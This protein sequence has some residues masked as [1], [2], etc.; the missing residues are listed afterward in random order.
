MLNDVDVNFSFKANEKKT[1]KIVETNEEKNE[2]KIQ[3]KDVKP[4]KDIPKVDNSKNNKDI[5]IKP[6][7]KAPEKNAIDSKMKNSILNSYVSVKKYIW[8]YVIIE[9]L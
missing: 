1:T 8:K 7:S 5:E 3:N 6:T 9:K 2:K 4:K